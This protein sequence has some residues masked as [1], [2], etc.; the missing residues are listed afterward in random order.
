[1]RFSPRNAWLVDPRS[2]CRL[3]GCAVSRTSQ[4]LTSRRSAWAGS[5]ALSNARSNPSDARSGQLTPLAAGN[6][7]S[8][9]GDGVAAL[10]GLALGVVLVVAGVL[11][12]WPHAARSPT[13]RARPE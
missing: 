2:A 11:P 8:G 3:R 7:N 13:A 1:M 10:D 9:V 5:A 4:R 6:A 12:V